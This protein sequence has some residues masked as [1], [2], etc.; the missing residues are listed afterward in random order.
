LIMCLSEAQRGVAIG[1][2]IGL[3]VTLACFGGSAFLSLPESLSDALAGRLHLLALSAVAPALALA[4]CIARLASHRF[5]SLR[6]ID[7]SGLTPGSERANL[8]QALL[9]NTL[10]QMVLALPVY[11]AMIVLAP[12]RLISAVPVA[13]MLFLFGRIQFF[14]GYRRGAAGRALGFALTFYPTLVLLIGALASAVR[15]GI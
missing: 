6:N 10:E 5:F 4:F 11:G 7:G 12:A 8:L 13:A 2:A 15:A 3:G 14:L 1:M 9:Q